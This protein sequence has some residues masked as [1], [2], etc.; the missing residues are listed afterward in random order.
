MFPGHWGRRRSIAG[1]PRRILAAVAFAVLA[2]SSGCFIFR[3]V[4]VQAVPR[5]APTSVR[6]A[7]KAH[8]AD[9]ST[10]LFPDGVTIEAGIV[11]GV[12][13]G[14]DL[15]LSRSWKVTAI[16]LDSVVAMESFRTAVNTGKTVAISTLAT[17]GGAAVGALALV[18]IFGSCPTVYS[19]S[20]GSLAL[21]AEAFSYSIAP[22][23]EMR[24]VDRLRALPV[25][26]E[27]RLE[28]RNEAL[29]THYLNHLELLEVRGEPRELLAPDPGGRTLALRDPVE[30]SLA[31]DRAGR[32]VRPLL[33]AADGAV[34]RSDSG[35][36][37]RAT[38]DDPDD[39]LELEIPVPVEA[40]SVGLYLRL[41]NSLLPTVLFY[42]LM[43]GARGAEALDWIGLELEEIGPA[44][45]LGRWVVE[46]LG[47]R[48]S[49]LDGGS[50]RRVARIPDSGPIAWKDVALLLPVPE[51]G[52]MPLRVRL[53]FPVDSWRIDRVA[54][55]AGWRRPEARRIPLDRV[56]DSA[57]RPDAAAREA[58]LEAD[59]AYLRTGPGQRFTAV[60]VAEPAGEG[61]QQTFFLASQ[62]YYIEW[63]R[64]RWLTEGVGTPPTHPFAP[65]RESLGEAIRRWR[66]V[67]PSMEEQF[68]STRIPVR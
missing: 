51:A 39:F 38:A 7:V 50:W 27:V 53:F 52:A 21:E 19:D 4:E 57:G 11:S 26:G 5:A 48:I 15:T 31:T 67:Q 59:E 24:D 63:V 2:M 37:A 1:P 64:G 66:V 40:D 42:D 29:E 13:T 6:S 41:R 65:N 12:G 9:G 33:R 16:A 62:G 60:F 35:L 55:F 68:W 25:G 36:L 45:E 10:V 49:V 22:L 18:A 32:D 17:A 14:H 54:A 58:L 20:A 30:L 43:L 3:S 44:V 34:F 46:H 23:F 47:M 8:L 56:V 61:V 28:I